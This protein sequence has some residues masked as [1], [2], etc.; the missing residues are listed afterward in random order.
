MEV[1]ESVVRRFLFSEIIPDA[2]RLASTQASCVYHR[3]WFK[4][5]PKQIVCDLVCPQKWEQ[6]IVSELIRCLDETYQQIEMLQICRTW[7][8][9]IRATSVRLQFG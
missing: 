5:S 7:R 2:S 6:T 1:F 9:F 4:K 8:T 3:G